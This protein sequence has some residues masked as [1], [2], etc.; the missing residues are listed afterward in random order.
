MTR[1]LAI[2]L[3]FALALP[4]VADDGIPAK[5][6]AE[7]KAATVFVKVETTRVAGSGSG[8]VVQVDKDSVLVVTNEHVVHPPTAA[9]PVRKLDVVFR[10]GKAKDEAVYPAEV[11]AA[12][13]NRDLAVLRVKKVTDPPKPIDLSAKAETTE[14][15]TVYAVGFPFGDALAT[16]DGNPAV[17][18]SKTSVSSLREDDQGELALVQLEGGVNPGNSGGPVVDSKGRLVGIS[19]AKVKGT[20]IGFAIPPM[21]LTKMLH[22]RVGASGVRVVSVDKNTAEVEF[23]L[24]FI[25][26]LE[27]VTSATIRLVKTDAAPPNPGKKG[28][29]PELPGGTDHV[30]KLSGQKG[31]I[32][33]KLPLA[34]HQMQ[35]TYTNEGRKDIR[36]AVVVQDVPTLA[37]RLSGTTGGG[38]PATPD[39]RETKP[40]PKPVNPLPTGEI[41]VGDLKVK[42]VQ[43]STEPKDLRQPGKRSGAADPC[44]TWTPDAKGFYAL[45]HGAETVRLFSFPELKE[46]A[47]LVVGKDVSWLSMSKEGLVLTVNGDQ[48]AWVLDPKT[49]KKGISFPVNK[50]IRVLSAP[51]LSVAYAFDTG[52]GPFGGGTI[53][54]VDLKT[55]K[56]VKEYEA[57]DMGKNIGLNTPVISNDGKHLFTTGGI[58]QLMHFALDGDKVTFVAAT[59]RMVSGAFN[60]P[61]VSADGKLVSAPSGGGNSGIK[62]RKPAPYSTYV[63]DPNNLDEP[64]LELKTGAYPRAIGFDTKAGLIFAQ[65]FQ[66]QLILLDREGSK[67]KSYQ[68]GERG[69]PYQFLPH[70]DG[71]KLLVFVPGGLLGRAATV[72]AVEIPKK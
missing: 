6:L 57:K 1:S 18:I 51:S 14:T 3:V 61:V 65:N 10:S 45:D 42:S 9:G 8:F 72:Y 37:R 15:M 13:A 52:D 26:P 46:E 23:T 70:P 56:K 20:N 29:I 17:T 4:S 43:T 67:L 47:K 36:T 69:E 62:G 24:E 68:L 64:I 25:D 50:A 63:F 22:G 53:R 11:L 5:T 12:D 58:E 59:E 55:G 49:L 7:I 54:V 66:D 31:S 38:T 32:K 19:V 48:E 71:W 35:I 34:K 27:K 30:I 44:L 40:L 21:E 2:G 33:V 28:V 60:Q 16:S 39:P 41:A